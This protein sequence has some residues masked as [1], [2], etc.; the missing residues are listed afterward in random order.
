MT[1]V[2]LFSER[3]WRR[4]GAPRRRDG[5]RNR[6]PVRVPGAGPVR[7]ARLA[8]AGRRRRHYPGRGPC[9]R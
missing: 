9:D 7:A 2:K 1:G 8:R 5:T 4:D 6:G 3:W